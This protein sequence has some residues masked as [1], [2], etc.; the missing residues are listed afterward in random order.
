MTAPA[1]LVT[2]G[3]GYIGSHT[4]KILHAA[5]YNPV[6]YDNLSTGHRHAVKWGELEEG[7][8]RDTARLIEVIHKHTPQAVMHFAAFIAAGESM[9]DPDKYVDNN[10][11]GTQGLLQAMRDTDTRRL[12]FSSTAAVYNTSSTEPIDE[13]RE[14]APENPYGATKARSEEM[15]RN[16]AATH[17]VEAVSLRYF[18]AAGADPDGELGEDHDPETHLIPLVLQVANQQRP[19]IGIFGDGYPTPDGT[20]IRDYVHVCDLAAAH[21][22]ALEFMDKR[23]GPG[24]DVFNLGNGAG[25]SVR[26]VIDT[27]R[28]VTGRPIPERVSAVRAGDPPILICDAAKARDV[29]GWTPQYGDLETQISHAWT[30]MLARGHESP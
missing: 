2:G 30:W 28:R 21:I 22:K 19:H 20:C 23:P 16:F 29:L 5:G 24:L 13:T 8:V 4:C 12:V 27:A 7:D 9:S 25:F 3:A 1:I 18:N 11:G 10:V 17:G 14:I 6:V 26:Q 15:I